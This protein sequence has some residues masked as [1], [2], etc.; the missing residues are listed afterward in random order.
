[1][2]KTNLSS[3]DIHFLVKE[4][5]GYV[6]ARIQRIYQE[7]K[8]SFSFVLYTRQ[9]K[10]ILRMLLPIAI[11]LDTERPKA[12]ITPSNLC[13]FLR[14]HIEGCNIIQIDNITK[15][16]IIEFHCTG[17]DKDYRL[18]IE[19][20]GEGNLI[21]CD[22]ERNILR[23]RTSRSWATRSTRNKEPYQFP[24]QKE[25]SG[26]ITTSL[27]LAVGLGTGKK[28]A[29]EICSR[30]GIDPKE[31]LTIERKKA[32]EKSLQNL[33]ELPIQASIVNT[34]FEPIR[35]QTV[36]GERDSKPSFSDAIKLLQTPIIQNEKEQVTPKTEKL[37]KTIEM[38]EGSAKKHEDK[39]KLKE[40]IGNTIYTEYQTIK[41]FLD[42]ANP[43]DLKAMIGTEHNG[44][45]VTE[46]D[47][48][49]KTITIS[50]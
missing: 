38:Q 6:G 23:A 44:W 28:F 19:L 5:Q 17:R 24:P 47:V 16:R 20:F 40:E 4:L 49:N 27:Y 37:R 3:I 46:V 25:L 42:T 1:M 41:H 29:N 30:S 50:K 32:V 18:L 31:P 2:T 12:S 8:Q 21:L 22:N 10:R 39:A 14:K 33:L 13:T 45:T 35:M 9:G 11:W 26:D 15:E 43:K 34:T 48:R 36:K 7:D